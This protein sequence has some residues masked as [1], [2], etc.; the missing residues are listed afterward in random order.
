MKRNRAEYKRGGQSK[1]GWHDVGRV[2]HGRVTSPCGKQR[3]EDEEEIR[4]QHKRGRRVIKKKCLEKIISYTRCKFTWHC[5]EL[6]EKENY[7]CDTGLYLDF[8]RCHYLRIALRSVVQECKRCI[9]SR[10]YARRV[11]RIC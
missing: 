8:S 6:N 1:K 4:R 9:W 2:E 5:L 3:E 7:E 10:E 11:N